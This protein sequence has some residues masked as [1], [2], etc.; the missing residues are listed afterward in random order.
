MEEIKEEEE[1]ERMVKMKKEIKTTL[2]ETKKIRMPEMSHEDVKRQEAYNMSP[3]AGGR[4]GSGSGSGSVM[5][6]SSSGR[7][8]CLCAPTTHPGSFRCRYHRR[9]SSSSSRMP[10][11]ISV[12]I[13]LSMMG[14][15]KSGTG[16]NMG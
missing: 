12:P 9:H 13:N 3:R 11:G 1:E 15:S 7:F 8:N 2:K 14:S 4:S 16:D 5:G 10:R 6:R